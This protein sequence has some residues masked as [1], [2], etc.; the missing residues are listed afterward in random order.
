MNV[1]LGILFTP[2]FSVVQINTDPCRGI[3]RPV[4]TR[5]SHSPEGGSS[6]PYPTRYTL[7]SLLPPYCRLSTLLTSHKSLL[8][9]QEG[10][11]STL[12]SVPHR[13]LVRPLVRVSPDLRHVSP[14]LRSNPVVRWW[15]PHIRPILSP[16]GI[17]PPRLSPF[18]RVRTLRL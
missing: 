11:P 16:I 1:G 17:F 5:T 18:H 9:H 10:R 2:P 7:L 8:G 13:P 4:P 12:L 3:R 14:N 15:C 6:F